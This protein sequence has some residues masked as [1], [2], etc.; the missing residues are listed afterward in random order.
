MGVSIQPRQRWRFV[1]RRLHQTVALNTSWR[2]LVWGLSEQ[3]A[4][5]T[6]WSVK[7]SSCSG[8]RKLPC[9]G[10]EMDESS[11]TRPRVLLGSH[12]TAREEA[13]ISTKPDSI[14]N[15]HYY[16]IAHQPHLHPIQVQDHNKKERLNEMLNYY[17]IYSKNIKSYM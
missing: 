15:I 2:S 17:T 1:S 5:D 6:D 4:S 13:Y 8:E 12:S 11:H 3:E 10:G 16:R 14:Y 9:V 7:T